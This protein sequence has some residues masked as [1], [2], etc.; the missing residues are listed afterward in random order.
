MVVNTADSQ[1]ADQGLLLYIGVR[2]SNAVYGLM[3]LASFAGAGSLMFLV[4]TLIGRITR[5]ALRRTVGWITGLAA[6]ASLPYLGIMLIFAIIGTV[7]VTDDV[8]VTAADGQSVLLVQ[9]GF[10]GDSVDIYTQQDEFHYKWARRAYELG[11]W[12]RVADQDCRLDT[13][14]KAQL[15]CGAKALTVE[16]E[17]TDR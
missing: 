16:Q 8:K 2:A 5:K 4:P 17:G 13:N 3:I 7:G 1:A 12:P 10:D 15:L 9:D 14:N 11:G 6:A